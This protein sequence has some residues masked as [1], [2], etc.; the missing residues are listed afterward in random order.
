MQHLREFTYIIHTSHSLIKFISCE[1]SVKLAYRC[2]GFRLSRALSR[3]SQECRVF[4]GTPPGIYIRSSTSAAI[5]SYAAS[6]LQAKTFGYLVPPI[7]ISQIKEYPRARFGYNDHF[8]PEI[9]SRPYQQ[10]YR[11]RGRTPRFPEKCTFI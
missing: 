11:T 8:F 9:R 5:R 10:E 3:R 2:S 6:P 1:K 4:T 7:V